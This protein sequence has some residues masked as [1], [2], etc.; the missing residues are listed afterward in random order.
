MQIKIE[1]TNKEMLHTACKQFLGRTQ[2]EI[3][4]VALETLEGHQ[5]G[6]LGEERVHLI[7]HIL[8]LDLVVQDDLLDHA[9]RE[10]GG[11][12]ASFLDVLAVLLVLADETVER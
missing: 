4:Y 12:R 9:T 7:R 11:L 8:G 2:A 6:E 3:E 10:L 1:S 5:R